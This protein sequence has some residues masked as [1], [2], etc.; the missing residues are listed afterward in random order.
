MQRRERR[1]ASSHNGNNAPATSIKAFCKENKFDQAIDLY[2]SNPNTFSATY[3]IKALSNQTELA[4]NR[5]ILEKIYNVYG[6]LRNPKSKARP[7]S[8]AIFVLLDAVRRARGKLGEVLTMALDDVERFE[9]QMGAYP[10]SGKWRGR[11][12]CLCQETFRSSQKAAN[13]RSEQGA[14]EGEGVEYS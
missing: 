2:H 6:A 14:G 9:I 5:G 3:L 7:D 12:C 13:E 1:E 11:G 4:Q 10:R 8:S